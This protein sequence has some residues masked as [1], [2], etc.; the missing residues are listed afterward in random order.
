[1]AKN[2]IYLVKQNTDG[3]WQ[4]I[5][6][7]N[8]PG[9]SPLTYDDNF[10]LHINT[11]LRVDE[12]EVN[13][14]TTVKDQ[15]VTTSEQLFVTNDGTGTAVVINQI[16]LDGLIDIQDDGQSALFIR[17]D[18]AF[19]G[20]VGLGTKQAQEQLHITGS[21][22]LEHEQLIMSYNDS[23]LKTPLLGINGD[24]FTELSNVGSGIKFSTGD[25]TTSPKLTILEN[26]N[27]GIGTT[28]PGAKLNID[29]G[30]PTGTINTVGP[31]KIDASS[32]SAES[33]SFE[34]EVRNTTDGGQ[35]ASLHAYNSDT[36][37]GLNAVPLLLQRSGGNVGIGTTDPQE[38]LH[39]VTT[40]DTVVRLT[41][42]LG[43][44]G[45]DQSHVA[46][47]TKDQTSETLMGRMGILTDQQDSN[48]DEALFL[49]SHDTNNIVFRTGS[50]TRMLIQNG[51]GNVGIGT[52]SPDAAL[53]ISH[54]TGDSLIL[55]KVSTEPSVRFKGDTD[56][57][58]VLTVAQDKFRI[59]PND[60]VTSLLEVAQSGNVGIGTTE[61]QKTLDVYGAI[62]ISNSK[63]SYWG[64]DR[65]D[66]DGSLKIDDTGTERMRIDSTGNVGIG[67]ASP[68]GKLEVNSNDFDT[69]YL[70]RDD[71]TGS[72]TIIL[73]NNSDSGCALQSTHGG[74]LKFFN[75]DDSGVLTPTQTIDSAGNI[76]IGTT[77]PDEKLHISGTVKATRAKLADLDIRSFTEATAGDIG[78]LL[79]ATNTS[80][81]G[82]IIE[83]DPNGQ[84]I[85]GIRGNDENDAFRIL[86]KNY[87]ASTT[88]EASRP[89]NH[90]A[91][92]VESRGNVG[93]GTASPDTPLTVKGGSLGSN[94][95]DETSL[96]Q[97]QGSRHKL[98]FKEERHESATSA[99]NWDGVTYKLQKKVDSTEMQSINFVHN[100][101]A[102]AIDNH[103]DLY[104]GGHTSTDPVFSTRFAGNGNVGIGTTSPSAKLHVKASSLGQEG[105][106][107]ENSLGKQTA[108]IGHLID[109]TAYFKLADAS[110]QNHAIIRDNGDSYLNA[111]GGNVGIGTT[112][113]GAQLHVSSASGNTINLTRDIDII[114]IANG[115]ASK[116]QGGAMSGVSPSMGGAIGFALLDSDG[117]GTVGNTEG[118]LYFETKDS[119]AS[120]TEK[121]RID[122]S[123]NV[124]IG[125]TDPGHKLT[126]LGDLAVGDNIAGGTMSD[127]VAIS[128]T[129]TS[130]YLN[131][132]THTNN[133]LEF[134]NN[135]TTARGFIFNS[136]NVGIGTTSPGSKLSIN[137]NA[138]A[139][140]YE[141]Y[142]N[143]ISTASE[144]IHRPTTGEF[145]IRANSQE[146]LRIDAAG[147]VGIGTTTPERKLE[148]S[149]NED[150]SSET[151]YRNVEGIRISNNN[152]TAGSL[153]ALMFK[154]PGSSAGI[155][156][157]RVSTDS[158]NLHIIS[159]GFNDGVPSTIMSLLAGGNVGI[160]ITNPSASLHIKN[161]STN[162][163]LSI[164]A[165]Q[166]IVS[167]I[168]STNDNLSLPAA[169]RTNH[170]NVS[171]QAASSASSQ[172]LRFFRTTVDSPDFMIDLDGVATFN[173]AIQANGGMTIV[174]NE[175]NDTPEL[176]LK[177]HSYTN[178]SGSDDIVDLRVS[179]SSLN[180]IINNDSDSDAGAY[181]FYKKSNNNEIYAPAYMSGLLIEGNVSHIGDSDTYF[182]FHNPDQ[183]RVVTGGSE[184]LEVTNTAISLRANTGVTGNLTISG[185][186]TVNG[187]LVTLNT[188]NLNIEDKII[189]VAKNA[190]TNALAD[191]SGIAFG[192]SA[193]LLYDSGTD[194]LYVKDCAGFNGAYIKSD[195]IKA[196]QIAPNA[197]GASELADNAV[198]TNAVLNKAITGAKIADN[199]IGTGQIA[200]SGVG[201]SE[202]GAKVVT[203]AKIADNTIT[204]GQIAANAVG[205]SEIAANAVGASE[206]ADNAVDTNAVLN[207]AITGGK[208]ADNTITAGQI[209]ADAVGAS[210]IAA[211]AVGSSELNVS[212][213]GTSGQVLTSDGDGTFSWTSKT[214][215]TDTNTQLTSAQISAMGFIKTDTNTQLTSA[216]ISA[217]GFIKTDTNTQRTDAEIKSVIS[218][219]GYLTS[220][221]VNTITNASVSG[222]TLTLDRQGGG[223]VSFTATNTA[224]GGTSTQLT[225]AEISAMGFSTNTVEKSGAQTMEGPLTI[226]GSNAS[227]QS[228]I[229]AG[230]V[231]AM[232]SASDERLKKNILKIDSAL[233][234][235]CSL[236]GFT[237]D[238]NDAARK[239]G[240]D[241][242]KKE[243]G[244]SAQK[245]EKVVPEAVKTFD[246]SDYKYINYEKLVPVLVEA[247]KELKSEIQELKNNC[248][249]NK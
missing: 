206:L 131:T 64:L 145:A 123:G 88:N 101:G 23:N 236:E 116:I 121:M 78:D 115:A 3:T 129:S 34:V 192:N 2:D 48:V 166:P 24:N 217:M 232:N 230:D 181:L 191:E 126:V 180:F 111:L 152:Q 157:E 150:N 173:N 133:G 44:S 141:F 162:N 218:G 59:S 248:G 76:G 99:V 113:P 174:T 184:R 22:L 84:M 28:S 112:S 243:V 142:E 46:F 47:Y 207:K 57:D 43:S 95:N 97:I 202:L 7:G 153:S 239:F 132:I 89:Y 146:R 39:I 37:S 69:L 55:E 120:L 244:L 93:I 41:Q 63:T 103:I 130:N 74:G 1:M 98:L 234:K 6:I 32:G 186:L 179:D 13:G 45:N 193:Q 33:A 79:P 92:C 163:A 127:G 72:A 235:V 196:A 11:K 231:I 96:A 18:N 42:Q 17:G 182:G 137:G 240:I 20:F 175:D 82:T 90:N 15:D 224:G 30:I 143:T 9:D 139:H 204:A 159:E 221:P 165:P 140:A 71:N 117:T 169:T 194:A 12:L 109:G 81:F 38:P 105:I 170:M 14:L 219:E 110:G 31:F 75:R 223:T 136:G 241:S 124:G 65:D 114:G 195:S 187:D 83:T 16:G 225:S 199:T 68:A 49:N 249:C 171:W 220:L 210:E 237:F 94:V 19:G 190:T 104:V 176:T 228:I 212:G 198:D 70:N 8:D 197:V 216:Q 233:D 67:T 144:C 227:N 107:V 242:A 246:E 40:S 161:S 172:G 36:S 201:T 108:H 125:T 151:D 200:A 208:I 122:S 52:T 134:N 87:V 178:P 61:P 213:N 60:G 51:T 66:S 203:G 247:I 154:T 156:A 86:T 118:Y 160:G 5:P 91:F 50:N 229:A 222:D 215:D 238:W 149:F 29:A 25:S 158:V 54:P 185:D 35:Y 62:G 183:W 138:S 209:A 177:R 245:T 26:G 189:Q 164:E 53:H 21:M 167:F 27:M 135:A 119:G 226:N 58:F 148:V 10:I 168:D 106:I 85:F 205:S 4:E 188:S 211:N 102:G 128:S 77:S 56:S 214:V 80:K 73:K 147:K 100:S 155:T